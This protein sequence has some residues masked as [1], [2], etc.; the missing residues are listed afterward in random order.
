MA[1]VSI[2]KH[3]F[4]PSLGILG[5][6][7]ELNSCKLHKICMSHMLEQ[8]YRT[9]QHFVCSA[10]TNTAVWC[11]N[12][13]NNTRQ[14]EQ[15]CQILHKGK[16]QG[17]CHCLDCTVTGLCWVLHY[18][19]FLYI[20]SILCSQALH[21]Y[22]NERR[23]PPHFYSFKSDNILFLLPLTYIQ[24]CEYQKCKS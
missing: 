5:N 12:G 11:K 23:C 16:H 8:L 20:S 21:F 15:N 2:F 14:A 19:R 6:I 13:H 17:R 22:I 1:L 4:Y 9:R 3:I 18:C 7:S 24:I 10:K